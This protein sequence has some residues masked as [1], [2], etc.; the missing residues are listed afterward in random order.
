[1]VMVSS[2]NAVI[3]VATLTLYQPHSANDGAT[4]KSVG[5]S[6]G[7]VSQICTRSIRFHPSIAIWF[8][9][10]NNRY[11]W[12]RSA[13]YDGGRVYTKL[14]QFS[15]P[16][17]KLDATASAGQHQISGQ[18]AE[19]LMN[20]AVPGEAPMRTSWPALRN[21]GYTNLGGHST[22]RNTTDDEGLFSSGLRRGILNLTQRL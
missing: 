10:P 6:F 17:P 7:Q 13:R 8:G 9:C 15:H 18:M 11:D 1:M 2:R 19:L 20:S 16:Q 12:P 22:Y 5:C 3:T 4:E 21:W 14:C